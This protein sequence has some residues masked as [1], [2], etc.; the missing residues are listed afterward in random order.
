MADASP[1]DEVTGRLSFVPIAAID[2]LRVE[3]AFDAK[4]FC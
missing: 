1:Q 4:T 2:Y 3:I